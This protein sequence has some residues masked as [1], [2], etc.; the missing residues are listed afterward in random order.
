M[1]TIRAFGFKGG[2]LGVEK[3]NPVSLVCKSTSLLK[4]KR[5]RRR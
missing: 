5:R 2:L 1:A 3:P 4:R